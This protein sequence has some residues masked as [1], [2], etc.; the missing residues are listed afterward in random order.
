M[1]QWRRNWC[2][3]LMKNWKPTSR[4]R[5]FSLQNKSAKTRA[6]PAATIT[7]RATIASDL[8]NYYNEI[9]LCTSLSTQDT[10]AVIVS[11]SVDDANANGE[12]NYYVIVVAT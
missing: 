2:P 11:S 12:N 3:S 9:L 10:D 6:H 7:F 8:W 4:P 1:Q 5:R